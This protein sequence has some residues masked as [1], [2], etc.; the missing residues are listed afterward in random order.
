MT[1]ALLVLTISV[2]CGITDK[3]IPD[4]KKLDCLE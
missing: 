3:S 4:E 2:F 1:E